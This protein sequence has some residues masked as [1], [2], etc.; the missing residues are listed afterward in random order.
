MDIS[1]LKQCLTNAGK[2]EL[3][4]PVILPSMA[5]SIFPLAQWALEGQP[6]EGRQVWFCVGNSKDIQSQL[7]P[8]LR[9]RILPLAPSHISLA[10]QRGPFDA[11]LL[12]HHGFS[13]SDPNLTLSSFWKQ[14]GSYKVCEGFQH[15]EVAL[16]FWV[17]NRKP[18]KLFGI[19]HHHAVQWDIKQLLRPLG[20]TLDFVWLCDG[21]P[22]INEAI[23]SEIPGFQ[24]SIDIY[25]PA[26]ET[27]LSPETRQYIEQ[28]KYDGIVTSHSLVT[29]Y[30]LK[31]IGL[32]MIHMNSTRFG[33]DWI[34]DPTKHQVLVNAVQELLTQGRL[35]I[36][37]NNQGDSKY[38]SQYFP[39][40]S[41]HQEVWIPS[42]CESLMRLRDKAPE[43]PKILIWDTRQVLLQE[44]G[45]PFMKEMYAKLKQTHGDKIESQ[46]VL[47]AQSNS[48]LPEGYLDS[49]SAVIH[50]PYNIS[51]MS[52][53]QQVRANIP[54]WVPSKKLL[55]KLLADTREPNEMSWTVFAPGSESTASLLDH[56]RTPE[57]IETW[58]QSADFYN[59]DVL[60]LVF[61]FDSIEDLVEKVLSTNYD[62][63]IQ[64]AEGVQQALRENITFA[65]EQVLSCLNK[66]A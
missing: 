50:I 38:F 28:K 14:R 66:T 15:T 62:G 37:H 6:T 11:L 60:P 25:R 2:E 26:P 55:A 49:Y 10:F 42:L 21:R 23:P 7:H 20:I 43:T 18:L 16:W 53:F 58:L 5:D 51:T 22:P 41:A 9:N 1:R 56:V 64:K 12:P 44:E 48:Y 54:I 33:N 39:H 52:M 35:R 63:A 30:R 13:Y 45:S 19:D 4:I 46:A 57:V 36:V 31:E 8:Q 47:M 61:Q 17:S 65:W 3:G 40:M 24:S 34:Q 29:C 59:P 32:P 27:P